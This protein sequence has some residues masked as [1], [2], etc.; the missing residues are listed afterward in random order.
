MQPFL[1][2]LQQSEQELPT[3]KSHPDI[4]SGE[5]NASQLQMPAFASINPP[6]FTLQMSKH[7]PQHK[8]T[9]L[10]EMQDELIQQ[11]RQYH[12]ARI[13]IELMKNE[14]DRKQHAL[15]EK[16]AE[17]VSIVSS[18]FCIRH[19]WVSFRR[20]NCRLPNQPHLVFQL[21]TTTNTKTCQHN[22]RRS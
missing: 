9:E 1:D 3:G 12:T 21:L 16:K 7:A 11:F 15:Q 8:W 17:E 2:L 18:P 13:E 10:V 19:L 20:K 4:A 6:G 14:L 22:S 5:R